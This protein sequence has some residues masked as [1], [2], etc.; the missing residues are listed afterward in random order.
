IS[1]PGGCQV[2]RCPVVS[3]TMLAPPAL[4]GFSTELQLASLFAPAGGDADG[5]VGALFVGV[6]AATPT[7]DIRAATNATHAT[8]TL[9]MTRLPLGRNGGRAAYY[10]RLNRTQRALAGLELRRQRNLAHVLRYLVT[11]LHR[12]PASD[13]EVP[14]LHVRIPVHVDRLPLEARDPGP[15]RDVGDGVGVG[16]E[17]AVGE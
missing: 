6:C 16:D 7:I 1:P 3:G 12:G 9:G 4:R 17:L 14:A 8:R 5:P 11:L 15:D 2:F 10:C 13:R